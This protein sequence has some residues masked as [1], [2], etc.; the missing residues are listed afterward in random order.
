MI[1]TKINKLKQK[2]Q[3]Q[4]IL[5]AT[6]FEN[7]AGWVGSRPLLDAHK[8][9]VKNHCYKPVVLD[10]CCGTG[11]VSKKVITRKES[12]II[13]LDL[14]L[15]M[16]RYAQRHHK[17]VINSDA[18]RLPFSN[19]SFDIVIC[20]QA[21]HFIDIPKLAGELKRILRPG[22]QIIIS[23]TVPFNAKDSAYLYKIHSVKQPL[24][25]NFITEE[26]VISILKNI[27][28]GQVKKKIVYI[29]ESITNWMKYSPE[30]SL[31]V[32]RNVL[33]LYRQ[34]PLNYKNL[35]QVRINNGDISERWKWVIVGGIKS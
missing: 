31:P 29:R 23:Q 17:T 33:D 6:D 16:I 12:T 2:I 15:S 10:L 1:N 18:S 35:H 11:I 8:K 19:E 34:A 25:K 30:L 14:S 22:G 5:R 4:F 3:R 7:S 28:C 9:L 24:L 13:G 20:R 21:L 27:G 32:R 26:D